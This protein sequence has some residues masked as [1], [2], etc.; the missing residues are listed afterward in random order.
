M[1][2]SKIISS[3]AKASAASASKEVCGF[4]PGA[5]LHKECRQGFPGVTVLIRIGPGV[6][7]ERIRPFASDDKP[8]LPVEQKVV[9]LA[10]S[11]L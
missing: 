4:N 2:L 3:W 5:A 8:F 1:I 11:G 7:Q 10:F 9:T 6:D